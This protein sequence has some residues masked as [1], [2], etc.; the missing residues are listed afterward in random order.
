MAKRFSKEILVGIGDKELSFVA[1]RYA[2][3]QEARSRELD[4]I[5]KELYDIKD[6][7]KLT[8]ANDSDSSILPST[9]VSKPSADG[10]QALHAAKEGR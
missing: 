9:M 10:M 1:L 8:I 7:K 5:K 3:E 2:A 4:D 6:F